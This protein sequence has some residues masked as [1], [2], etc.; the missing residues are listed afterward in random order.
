MKR[1][2]LRKVGKIGEANIEARK[3]IAIIAEEKG[4]NYCELR[5]DGCTRTWP[6]APAHRHKRSWYQGDVD[7]LSAYEQWISACQNCHD[8]IEHD[9]ELTEKTFAELRP[10]LLSTQSTV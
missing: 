7:L 9:A 1:T 2:P 8:L 4:L 5:L 6:L 10:T 3:R